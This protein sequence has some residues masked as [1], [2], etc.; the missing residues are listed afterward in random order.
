MFKS[1]KKRMGQRKENQWN[2]KNQRRRKRGKSG[3]GVQVGII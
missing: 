3:G 1:V 2:R